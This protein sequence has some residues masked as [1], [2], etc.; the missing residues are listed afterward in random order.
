MKNL[1]K[2]KSNVV[3]IIIQIFIFMLGIFTVSN[4]YAAETSTIQTKISRV[5]IQNER[6]SIIT[7]DEPILKKKEEKKS[8]T[9]LFVIL[10]SLLIALSLFATSGVGLL[11]LLFAWYDYIIA[12]LIT[13]ILGIPTV[14]FG[15]IFS[16]KALIKH[17]FKKNPDKNVKQAPPLSDNKRKNRWAIFKIVSAIIGITYP[18]VYFLFLF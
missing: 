1:I 14:V 13:L 2:I 4:T 12:A 15:S 17:F 6:R 16:F 9:W 3:L 8:R 10:A 18:I 7:Q 11:A 5:E